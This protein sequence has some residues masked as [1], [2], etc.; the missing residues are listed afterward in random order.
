M[1]AQCVFG[2]KVEMENELC[3]RVKLFFL[4]LVKVMGFA[5]VVQNVSN[6][7]FLLMSVFFVFCVCL[8]GKVEMENE[9]FC[10]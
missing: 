9:L 1:Q 5:Y 4:N 3:L 10:D 2:K 8:F 6:C 7:I